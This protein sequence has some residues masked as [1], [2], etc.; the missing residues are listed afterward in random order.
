MRKSVELATACAERNAKNQTVWQFNLF[1]P[2]PVDLDQHIALSK[3]GSV[4]FSRYQ[5]KK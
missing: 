2:I 4:F 1:R 5:W 3:G